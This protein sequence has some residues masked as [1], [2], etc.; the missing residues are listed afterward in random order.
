MGCENYFKIKQAAQARSESLQWKLIVAWDE[1]DDGNEKCLR[2]NWTQCRLQYKDWWKRWCNFYLFW[3]W[4]LAPSVFIYPFKVVSVGYNTITPM[5]F[6]VFTNQLNKLSLYRLHV[7]IV[8][9]CVDARARTRTH[10][11][12]R[13]QSC[14][15]I[16]TGVWMSSWVRTLSRLQPAILVVS[17][18]LARHT[19]DICCSRQS[20]QYPISSSL[21]FS[22]SKIPKEWKVN[23]NQNR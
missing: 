6:S 23:F 22:S 9:K 3:K 7:C 13:N 18:S 8:C 12:A 2:H 20:V 21:D 16:I 14:S 15:N 1:N 4:C 10:T 19:N 5:C 11:H 17:P